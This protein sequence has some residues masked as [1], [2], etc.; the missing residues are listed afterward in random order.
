M[1]QISVVLSSPA[2]AVVGLSSA[3]KPNCFPRMRIILKLKNTYD[4][5]FVDFEIAKTTITL[6]STKLPYT[7]MLQPQYPHAHHP[8]LSIYFPISISLGFEL[9]SPSLLL[10]I[11]R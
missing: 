4:T 2:Q 7:Q 10:P 3:S 11:Q 1:D 6:I 8:Y 9:A 5:I